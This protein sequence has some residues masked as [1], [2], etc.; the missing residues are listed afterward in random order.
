[1]KILVFNLGSTSLKLTCFIKNQDSFDPVFSAEA[2]LGSKL[3]LHF[4]EKEETK[5]KKY[6]NY[7][8][9][10]LD[11]KKI[12][13]SVQAV[14]HRVVHGATLFKKPTLMSAANLK[15]LQKLENLAPLHNP[16]ECQ[17][18]ALS[19]KVWPKAKVYAAFDT[20]YF[21]QMPPE[22]VF[23]PLPKSYANKGI[24]HYGFHGINHQA[25]T[26][27]LLKQRQ[28]SSRSKIISCHLGGGC[29]LAA[30]IGLKAIDTTMGFSPLDGLIMSTRSGTIDPGILLFLL[31]NKVVSLNQ[32][33]YDLNHKSGLKALYPPYTN[34][35]RLIDQSTKNTKAL[36]A[37]NQF[38]D[39]LSHHIAKMYHSLQGC[40][41]LIFS[42]GIGAHSA[43][44]RKKCL[45]KL[46][47]LGFDLDN[48]L[49]QMLDPF[50]IHK[51]SSKALIAVI[52][53]L[54]EKAIAKNAMHFAT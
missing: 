12:C 22:K 43:W 52:P 7:E 13:G 4:I 45:I 33:E 10:F 16:K 2:R 28:I 48:K 19:K 50:W 1:M 8:Q 49:N 40:D 9:L 15:K 51:K 6:S 34:M 37:L 32:L 35:Q 20:S 30:S 24:R 25:C 11:L 53:S 14:G 5:S 38:I 39:S 3:L 27:V 17:L 26:E 36:F 44:I 23:Y 54:E 29:S 18:I 21:S 31:K 42:G 47:Y 46:T 41:A